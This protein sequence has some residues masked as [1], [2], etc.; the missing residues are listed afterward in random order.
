MISV[1]EIESACDASLPLDFSTHDV[2]APE[3]VDAKIV[4][5]T[6]RRYDRQISRGP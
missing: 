6:Y 2:E 5:L 4:R 3:L 1:Q